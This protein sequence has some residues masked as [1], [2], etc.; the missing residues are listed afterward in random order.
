[1][2]PFLYPFAVLALLFMLPVL[3]GCILV[4]I[5]MGYTF[6]VLGSSFRHGIGA[7]GLLY[8]YLRRRLPWN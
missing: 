4:S 2:P 8:C 1:M 5:F 6:F 7:L 3:S